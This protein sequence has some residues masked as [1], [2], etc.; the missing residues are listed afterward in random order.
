MCHSV[1]DGMCV[2]L[3]CGS[4]TVHGPL[5]PCPDNVLQELDSDKDGCAEPYQ[6][7]SNN[8]CGNKAEPD[9]DKPPPKLNEEEFSCVL[10]GFMLLTQKSVTALQKFESNDKVQS[11]L[12]NYQ[13]GK[14]VP[15]GRANQAP[16]TYM[17][18]LGCMV[19]EGYILDPDSVRTLPGHP[20][21]CIVLHRAVRL[22]QP[23]A[24]IACAQLPGALR[25]CSACSGH[26]PSQICHIEPASRCSV[27]LLLCSCAHP[28][29]ACALWHRAEAHTTTPAAHRG[30]TPGAPT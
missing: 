30:T 14:C 24:A 28:C 9:Y 12:G 18:F 27:K 29:R 10:E 3:P 8:V 25:S 6:L 2:A 13:V 15:C 20:L 7:D 19:Q 23:S 1:Q 17:D 11:Y 26:M 21:I 4:D 5:A 16:C 22:L